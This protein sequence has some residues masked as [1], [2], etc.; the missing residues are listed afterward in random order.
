LAD[1][2]QSVENRRS[3]QGIDDELE[4]GFLAGIV[5]QVQKDHES[6]YQRYDFVQAVS[7]VCRGKKA[8]C[9]QVSYPEQEKSPERSA[10][11]NS[12]GTLS[13]GNNSEPLGI[14]K[15]QDQIGDID[16]N[17]G[18]KGRALDVFQGIVDEMNI[19]LQRNAQY[20]NCYQE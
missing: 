5:Y 16:G 3:E 7:K 2:K 15:E 8:R 14:E 18:H 4:I 6:F 10:Q 13:E 9:K 19:Q 11:T 1:Y 20:Q 12:A 17:A